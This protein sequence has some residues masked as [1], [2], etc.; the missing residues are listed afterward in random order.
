MLNFIYI[1]IYTEY[2]NSWKNVVF[3]SNNKFSV[4]EMQLFPS[5]LNKIISCLSSV[6]ITCIPS[7]YHLIS[8]L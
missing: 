5:F 4:Y 3:F 6:H 1:I 8:N 7:L 2:Q